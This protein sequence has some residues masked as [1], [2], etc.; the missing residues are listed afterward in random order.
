MKLIELN[1]KV[2]KLTVPGKAEI[3][4]KFFK[5][6][7]GEYGYGD[8]FIGISVPKLRK[9]A[10]EFLDLGL[11]EIEVLLKENVHEKRLIGLL[12]LVE[13]YKKS[14][15]KTK[16]M[17]F[18]FYSSHLESINNWDLVDLTADK[19]IGDYLLDNDREI[20]YRMV[21]SDS[22]WK[23]RI[24]IISTFA[25]IRKY[26]FYDALKIS[27][28]LLLDKEDL[29]HKAV[30]W[31]LR[32][33]GKRNVEVLEEFLKRNYKKMPRTMLRYAI[34]KFDESKRKKYLRGEI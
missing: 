19:I 27:E 14:D 3:Y 28:I 25:F 21:E 22:L 17:I 10:K 16:K 8:K 9:L 30:G 23:R 1:N 29:I 33:I 26:Q 20:L 7:K 34:E 15:K 6:N 24:A 5:T 2:D 12:I 4:R 11:D 18:N 31:M 32:E 13:N